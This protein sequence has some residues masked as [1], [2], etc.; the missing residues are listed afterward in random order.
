MKIKI[1][2][3]KVLTSGNTTVA[4]VKIA[5]GYRFATG[6][7]KARCADGD[8][9]DSY[10]GKAIACKRAVIKATKKLIKEHQAMIDA[11]E[12]ASAKIQKHTDG[13]KAHL[14]QFENDLD[15]LTNN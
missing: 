13:L 4:E 14:V 10:T 3:K 5:D 15:Y 11:Y 2:S 1:V 9:F 12:K 8:E 6:D 7:G